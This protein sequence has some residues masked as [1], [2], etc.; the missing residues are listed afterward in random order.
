MGDQ[1]SRAPLTLAHKLLR[2]DGAER[3]LPFARSKLTQMYND[4]Q[5]GEVLS[6]TWFADDAVIRIAMGRC[7]GIAI[8]LTVAMPCSG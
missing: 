5:A 3:Y 4:S 8:S 7:T 6:R 2:G 1:R